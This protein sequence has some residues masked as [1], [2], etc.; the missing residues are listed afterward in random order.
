MMIDCPS[1]ATSYHVTAAALG[2]GRAVVCPRC[3]ARWFV[4]GTQDTAVAPEVSMVEAIGFAADRPVAR[5]VM[6]VSPSPARRRLV[7]AVM[8]AAVLVVAVGLATRISPVRI[9]A[10]ALPLLATIGVQLPPSELAVRHLA[11]ERDSDTAAAT[12]AVRGEIANGGR[13]AVTVPDLH[14]SIADGSGAELYRWTAP[15]PARRLAAGASLAFHVDLPAVPVA[16]QAVSVRFAA[17][18]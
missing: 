12:L 8:A 18:D 9:G 15:P 3:A 13:A 16:G 4:P 14:F 2:A 7:P 6:A 1:C 5:R 11:G 17:A 10:A